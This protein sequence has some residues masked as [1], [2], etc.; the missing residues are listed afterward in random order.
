MLKSDN[1]QLKFEKAKFYY[2]KKD[3]VRALPLFEEL[4]SVYKGTKDVEEVYYYYSY[5][6][7]GQGEYLMSAYHFKNFVT[8]YPKSK[9]SEEC[10][11]MYAYCYYLMSP[12][13]TLDQTDTQKAIN[14]FQLF[15]NT[16]PESARVKQSND[17]M[18]ELRRKMELKALTAAE[19]YYKMGNYKSATVA[20][21]NLLK[22]FPDIPES[23]KVHYLIVNS[24]YLLAKESIPSK[25]LERF[26][27]T[28]TAYYDFI[29]K[30]GNSNYLREAE[31]IYE[32]SIESLKKIKNNEYQN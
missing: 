7:Y 15:I 3:Y 9:Y 26:N 22:D 23:E 30:F 12:V 28:I 8:T 18:D 17:L 29:D 6:Y 11:Y 5:C 16:Y 2:N 32:K 10:H 21:K 13:Y 19:L 14:A 25:K 1:L 20:F 24:W 31:K 27:S 4:V